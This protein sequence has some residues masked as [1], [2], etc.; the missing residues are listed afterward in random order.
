MHYF[1]IRILSLAATLLAICC[2]LSGV[3]AC[4]KDTILQHYDNALQIGGT[5][6]R[7]PDAALQGIRVPGADGYT[8]AYTAAY[9]NFSG[10][11]ILF[12]GTALKR[13]AGN[14]VTVSCT[15]SGTEGQ[16][17][18]LFRSGSDAP[19]TLLE[20]NGTFTDTLTLPAGSN[21]IEII[22]TG[23]SGELQ[24]TVS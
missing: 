19:K 15:L 1:L 16:A 4:D 12:G 20:D 7:T 24:I 18:L 9:R 21:S 2:I 13:P 10:T 11:E 5:L 22:L 17:K 3:T 6:A 8:G 23:Y 14:T